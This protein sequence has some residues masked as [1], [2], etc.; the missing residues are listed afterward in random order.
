MESNEKI[1]EEVTNAAQAV[2]A[3]FAPDADFRDVYDAWFQAGLTWVHFPI[4][5]GGLALPRSLQ[6]VADAILTSAGWTLP[7][8]FN[9]NACG[10]VAPTLIEFADRALAE[11]HI[12]AIATGRERWCQLFSEP[13]AGS[14]LASLSTIAQLEG[15]AWHL[16]G[17]KVWSSKAHEADWAILLARTDPDV[18][19]HKGITYF[20]VDMKSAGIDVRPLRQATGRAEFNEVFLDE[21]IIPDA[22]RI[23]E[24]NGGWPIARTTLAHERMSVADRHG[25]KRV[26]P[27]DD[28]IATW[29]RYPER[30][31]P[32]ARDQL[33]ALWARAQAHRL[34]CDRLRGDPAMKQ[35][36]GSLAKISGALLNQA[37]YEFSIQMMGPEAA[38]FGSYA[39]DIAEDGDYLIQ[40][41]F[42][43][44]RANSIEGGTTE[45]QRNL[46]AERI[47][48]LPEEHKPDRGKSWREARNH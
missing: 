45:I 1:H 18:P 16:T 46:V 15:D 7:R 19:K 44:S 26:S 37:C 30:Q 48:G 14:D 8:L 2:V 35:N 22:N 36:E 34:T 47:L 40:E 4:G 23:G 9:K 32:V 5:L 33:A 20:I 12:P 6:G 3:Q 31:N 27:I 17:Q 39:P 10:F 11:R 13:G 21:V 43:R 38:L 41:R 25:D 42:L 24:I 29:H 28:A